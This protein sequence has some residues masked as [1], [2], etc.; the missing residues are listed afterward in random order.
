MTFWE[1]VARGEY[2]MIPLAVCF[3][4]VVCIW[5]VRSVR[6]GKQNRSYPSLMHRVRDNVV[7]G[8]I[9]NARQ[10]CNHASTPGA[11]TIEAGLSHVGKPLSEVRAAMQ[12]VSTVEKDIMGRGLPWLKTLAVVTPLLGL[13]G[14][15]VGIIDRLRDLGEAAANSVELSTICSEIAPTIVTTVAGLGVGIF[16]LIASTCLESKI[17]ASR[18]NLDNLRVDLNNL[19]NEPS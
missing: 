4:L 18:R 7:E 16:A 17:E 1:T 14:T 10:Y 8:D 3:I 12:G 9:D 11:R 6:L 19:L 13:G 15:L 2:I 5:W